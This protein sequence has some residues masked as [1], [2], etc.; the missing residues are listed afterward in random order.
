MF[1]IDAIH[2]YANEKIIVE[3]LQELAKLEEET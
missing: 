3:N 2:D 1:E